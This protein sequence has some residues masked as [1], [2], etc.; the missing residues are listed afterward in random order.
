M[1][2]R[3]LYTK[4]QFEADKA[5]GNIIKKLMIGN[6]QVIIYDTYCEKTEEGI[7]RRLDNIAKIAA[8]NIGDFSKVVD[9]PYKSKDPVI[10]IGVDGDFDEFRAK[11]GM[12]N[13]ETKSY[14]GGMEGLNVVG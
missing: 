7:K 14:E 9:E 10:D 5:N 2:R 8:R 3:G 12:Y 6:T 13:H 11:Y 4:E 1:G